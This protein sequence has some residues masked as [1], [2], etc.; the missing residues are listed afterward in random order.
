MFLEEN[1]DEAEKVEKADFVA[2]PSK[3]VLRSIKA[4]YYLPGCAHLLVNVLVSVVIGR[5]FYE[6]PT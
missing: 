6:L 5:P 2:T 4:R 3:L 1:E